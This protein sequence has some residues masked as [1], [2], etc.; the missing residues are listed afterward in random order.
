MKKNETLTIR[1][2]ATLKTGKKSL[3]RIQKD[4]NYPKYITRQVSTGIQKFMESYETYKNESNQL[5]MW[6]TQALNGRNLWISDGTSKTPQ[7]EI[8][9]SEGLRN[10]EELNTEYDNIAESLDQLSKNMTDYLNY[11]K[12]SLEKRYELERTITNAYAQLMNNERMMEYRIELM[13][14]Q[15]ESNRTLISSTAYKKCRRALDKLLPLYGDQ[16][17]EIVT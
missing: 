2:I 10:L 8:E 11:K 3:N 9:M 17:I 5:E 6:M 15:L 4:G 16:K 13:E 7:E 1:D 14:E 12:L